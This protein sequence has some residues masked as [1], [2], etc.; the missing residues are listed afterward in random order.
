MVNSKMLKGKVP[1]TVFTS[2]HAL[3]LGT[4]LR[5]KPGELSGCTSSE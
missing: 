3:R 2:N 4:S 1:K 5:R